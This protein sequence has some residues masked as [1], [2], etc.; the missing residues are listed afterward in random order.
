MISL[1]RNVSPRSTSTRSVFRQILL[2]AALFVVLPFA[3]AQRNLTHPP[4][5]PRN[6]QIDSLS[7]PADLT[8]AWLVHE[9]DDPDFADP[10]LDDSHWQVIQS[11]HPLTSYGIVHPDFLWYRTHVHLPPHSHSLAL[12]LRAFAG[13][14]Q[15]FVNGVLTGPS[16]Q[17]PPGGFGT[18]SF[19]HVVDLPDSLLGT[20]DLTIAVRA[21]IKRVAAIIGPGVGFSPDSLFVLGDAFTLSDKSSLYRFRNVT[22]NFV[23]I[24]LTAVVL[25][26]AVA[27]ALTLRKEREY[28]ALCVLL[29]GSLFLEC[30]DIWGS[31]YDIYPS[32]WTYLPGD[33]GRLITLLAGIEFA[34]IV[35][36]L[37]RNRWINGYMALLVILGSLDALKT[38]VQ[39][40]TPQNTPGFIFF[41]FL[42]S[43]TVTSPVDL[44]LPIFSLFIWRKRKNFDALLLSVPILVR[45]LFIYGQYAMILAAILFHRAIQVPGV[46]HTSLDIGW[47]EVGD[48]CFHIALLIFLILRTVRIARARAALTAELEAAR[49]VQQLLITGSSHATPGF[50]VESVYLPASEVGGDF[51][52]VSP[53]PT[54]HS[55]IAILGDVSGK[56]LLAAMR[57]S[58]ILGVLRRESSRNP[59]RIL[60]NLNE[61][62]HT[63]GDTGFTTACCL[64]LTP[65]GHFTI[66]NAGHISPYLTGKQVSLELPAA[67]ALPLGI[68]AAQTYD[69]I[70]GDLLPG[71]RLILMSDGIP[72]ARS[73]KGEL[74]GFDRLPTLTQLAAHDIAD[75]AQ[76]FGQEDD[77]TVLTLA[78]A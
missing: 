17:F 71:Q 42:A 66:A 51:F 59:G 53:H 48:F 50:L 11:G 28:L 34:R 9:G 69:L 38:I 41:I 57:V 75:V 8:G 36:R 67:P 58:M 65:T 78:I 44:G 3:H 30:R 21:Q 33:L 72:E 60:A 1:K 63:Q 52:L 74:Y 7:R 64:H 13:S 55:L 45:S 26:I 43:V 4:V 40:P 20:G 5:D 61:A 70:E 39:Y 27:L 77:I 10:H 49:T 62:L 37:P 31:A 56:G 2:F 68:A 22:S 54:D 46:P 15:V 73:Q 24:A 16:R 29:A 12:E 23:N 32:R 14:E 35:L 6:L 76:R 25:L 47:T 19:D 18:Q